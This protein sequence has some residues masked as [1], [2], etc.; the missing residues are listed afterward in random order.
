MWFE[1]WET[2]QIFYNFTHPDKNI[3]DNENI[4]DSEKGI[5]FPPT[6]KPR[7]HLEGLQLTFS[8]IKKKP[9]MKKKKKKKI[10]NKVV[11]L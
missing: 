2:T 3:E 8:V 10:V 9:S 4:L 7:P 1:I 5:A 11:T 6:A